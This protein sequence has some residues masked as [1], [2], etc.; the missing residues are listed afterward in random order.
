M[1][2]SEIYEK[3]KIMPQ[4]ELHML[5]VAGAAVLICDNLERE[6]DKKSIITAC[7]LHDMGKAIKVD[8]TIGTELLEKKG[9]DY[10]KSVKQDFVSKYGNDADAATIKIMHELDISEKITN[11]FRG[12]IGRENANKIYTS[13]DYEIKILNYT[14][15]RV[16][17]SGIS[18]LE[19]RINEWLKRYKPNLS[20]GPT[21]INQI[22]F[23]LN[24]I[25]KQIFDKCK[26]KPGDI[27]EEKVGPLFAGLLN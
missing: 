25:E 13:K 5:R 21:D 16:L 15:W 17:P 6:V 22:I 18:S 19:K 4:V 11:I 27:T 14:D 20:E 24:G 23:S 12:I 10:W 1:K 7:L 3:Y 8:F 2:I 9:L 26:I